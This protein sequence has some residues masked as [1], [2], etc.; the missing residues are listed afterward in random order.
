MRARGLVL[1]VVGV[2]CCPGQRSWAL[3]GQH[4]RRETRIGSSAGEWRV[5]S[6]GPVASTLGR[7]PRFTRRADTT[8]S[9]FVYAIVRC[10]GKQSRAP[11]YDVLDL[12]KLAGHVGSTATLS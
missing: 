9:S 12:D 3:G 4:G 10:G 7:G 8:E 1:F 2:S 5:M 6:A 11:V